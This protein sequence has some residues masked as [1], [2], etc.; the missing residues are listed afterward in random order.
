MVA[1]HLSMQ[2]IDR[3]REKDAV[4]EWL[5]GETWPYHGTPLLSLEQALEVIDGDSSSTDHQDFW[6]VEGANQRSG[7]ARIFD[8]DDVDDGTPLLDLRI[9]A[10]RRNQGIGQWAVRWLTDYGF[11]T[12]PQMHRLGGTTR[13]D[14]IAMRK[15]FKRCGYAKEGHFRQSWLGGDGKLYDTIFYTILRND[16]TTGNSTPVNWNDDLDIS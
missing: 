7:L 1:N 13:A 9:A 10:A 8:L 12:W 3:T 4:A 5:T 15:V 11:R 14:N 2:A 6:I 16:W